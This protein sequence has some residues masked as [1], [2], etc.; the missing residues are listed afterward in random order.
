MMQ[1]PA[2]CT[3]EL[4]LYLESTR[5]PWK[6]SEQGLSVCTLDI[7]ARIILWWGGGR[8]GH[9]G[10]LRSIP[11]PHSLD[12]RSA[13]SPKCPSGQNCP[14]L[15]SPGLGQQRET[16]R[17]SGRKCLLVVGRDA[18]EAGGQE[19]RGD[20]QT[21]A[22]GRCRLSRARCVEELLRVERAEGQQVG[23]K[24]GQKAA[25]QEGIVFIV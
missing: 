15:R 1:D 21:E 12:P 16:T 24:A 19:T 14:Q 23:G 6:S 18:D 3:E 7:L 22:Q 5:E 17:A 11:G 13:P 8:P 2:F 9:C 10:V 4:G 25:A 20:P